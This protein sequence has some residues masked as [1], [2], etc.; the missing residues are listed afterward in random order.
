MKNLAKACALG[1]AFA[2][3]VVTGQ[4]VPV[5]ATPKAITAGPVELTGKAAKHAHG[6]DNWQQGTYK[7]RYITVEATGYAPLDPKAI[8]GM[9]YSGDPK[10]T[11]SGAET[12]PGVTVAAPKHMLFG[13]KVI[14]PGY[15]LRVVEDRGGAITDNKLDICFRT[16]AEALAFGRQ[17][18][19]I[20]VFEED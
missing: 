10:V 9:C 15:G 18:I 7:V 16:Q 3:G 14:V 12:K 1:L 2:A 11:A 8:K 6:T 13:T 5:Q 20:M 17:N 19:E 4:P